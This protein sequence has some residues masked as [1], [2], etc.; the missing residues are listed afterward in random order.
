MRIL[1]ADDNLL[2]RQG[3]Q[4]LLT[5]EENWQVCGE[6]KDGAEAL[7][8]AQ[9]LLPDLLLLD[10][11]MPGRMGGLDVTRALR[12]RNPNIKIVIMSQ[13]DPLQL[14]PRAL[15]AGADGCV[16]KARLGSD[17]VPNIKMAT[18]RSS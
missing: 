18:T 12:Q 4:R 8:M 15:E 1:I 7:E 10:L 6:A 3:V 2:I 13:H 9:T 5:G 11:S 14:L 17:L 16:D